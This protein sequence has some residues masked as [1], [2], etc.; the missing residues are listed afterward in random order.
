MRKFNLEV[1]DG[2]FC[3]L[4][5]SFWV[6]IEF[7]LG[8]H[9]TSF[10][11][12]LYRGYFSILLPIIF[13]FVALKEKQSQPNGILSINE[14]INVGFRTVLLSS[15]I[16]T[17]FLYFYNNHINP[18]WIERMAEWQ[19]KNLSLVVQAM[20]RLEDLWNSTAFETLPLLREL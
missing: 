6:L 10:E 18:D 7:F 5:M 8:F 1:T 4:A 9:T 17:V 3:G 12:G 20:M 14:G 2:L 19:R 16:F 15:I 11:I 13:I